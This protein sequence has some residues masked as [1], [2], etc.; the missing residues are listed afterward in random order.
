MAW[1]LIATLS[2]V[3]TALTFFMTAYNPSIY[4]LTLTLGQL[5]NPFIITAIIGLLSP[6]FW[7]LLISYRCDWCFRRQLKPSRYQTKEGIGTLCS[8][9]CLNAYEAST[10]IKEKR[11]RTIHGLGKLSD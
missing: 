5:G 7:T 9:R 4:A 1:L 2:L 6:F 3:T 11:K 10:D 8:L